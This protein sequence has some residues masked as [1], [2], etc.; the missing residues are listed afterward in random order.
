M[1]PKALSAGLLQLR[2][3]HA[4][5]GSY[6]KRFGLEDTERCPYGARKQDV[7]HLILRCKLWK[8]ERRKPFKNA[9]KNEV[10]LSPRLDEKVAVR[11]LTAKPLIESMLQFSKGNWS[12]QISKR[13]R[14]MVG[15]VGCP[16]V[17]PGG[18][19]PNGMN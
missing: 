12:R 11:P 18:E 16:T 9:R 10:Y 2:C 7:P 13:E 5:I 19:E 14:R 4:A 6:R 1:H 3:G 17:R 8:R 15:P